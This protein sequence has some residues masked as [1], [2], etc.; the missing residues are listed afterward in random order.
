MSHNSDKQDPD[1]NSDSSTEDDKETNASNTDSS[2]Q[3]SRH[4]KHKKSSKKK[5]A[6]SKS[7]SPKSKKKKNPAPKKVIHLDPSKCSSSDLD[8]ALAALI[9]DEDLDNKAM[10]IMYTFKDNKKLLYIA[11][12]KHLATQKR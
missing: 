5:K 2:K 10:M 12:S 6:K 9:S 3:S 4:S 7:K 1:Y 8:K 11:L